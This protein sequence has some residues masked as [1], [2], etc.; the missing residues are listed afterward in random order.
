MDPSIQSVVQII[1]STLSA[2]DCFEVAK[3]YF[4]WGYF[5]QALQWITIS[6]AWMKEEYS[7]VYEVL[8]MTRQDVALLQ[9]RCLVEL[10]R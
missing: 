5:K 6:K 10:G 2:L 3:M 4:K 9:A 8:G 1:S 7:G